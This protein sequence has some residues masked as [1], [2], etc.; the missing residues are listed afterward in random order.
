MGAAANARATVGAAWT[1]AMSMLFPRLDSV[2]VSLFHQP[3]RWSSSSYCRSSAAVPRQAA[4]S[5]VISCLLCPEVVSFRA[6]RY[7]IYATKS[8]ALSVDSGEAK[9]P[10]AAAPARTRPDRAARSDCSIETAEQAGPRHSTY[11]CHLLV[12]PDL[13][14]HR[15]SVSVASRLVGSGG[16]HGV[17]KLPFRNARHQQV[18]R[19]LRCRSRSALSVLR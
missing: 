15:N 2:Q 9:F 8:S 3:E 13:P 5:P 1:T 18:L 11:R 14:C 19:L 6:H 16:A 12:Q 17:S 4:V 7:T 10:D